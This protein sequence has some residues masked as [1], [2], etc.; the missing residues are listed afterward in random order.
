MTTT[1][2]IFA[3]GNTSKQ[4]RVRVTG[5]PDRVLAAG[6]S[7]SVVIYDGL[8]LSIQEEAAGSSAPVDAPPPTPP[9]A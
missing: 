1:V 7:E 2:N 3:C 5:Q 8:Q 9:A 4:V 6:G